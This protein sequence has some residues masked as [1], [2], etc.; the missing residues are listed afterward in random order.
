MDL[1]TQWGKKRLGQIERV[2]LT[3][4]RY[5]VWNTQLAGSCWRAQGTQLGA[6]GWPRG[7][8]WEWGGREAPK[9]GDVCIHITD[10]LYCTA[11]ALQL[12]M[13]LND[14]VFPCVF[15]KLSFYVRIYIYLIGF[16][17]KCSFSF[18]CLA[19]QWDNPA[20]GRG[21]QIQ[22]GTKYKPWTWTQASGVRLLPGAPDPSW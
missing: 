2:A 22:R 18:S 7:V 4:I 5:H 15:K 19:H 13:F 6:L 21:M 16:S 10:S 12:K 3:Y 8:G 9:G 14:I 1:Q 11:I 17:P 20:L